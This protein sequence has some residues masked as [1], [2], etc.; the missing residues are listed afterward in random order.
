MPTSIQTLPK[1]WQP[2]PLLLAE[3]VILVTGVGDGIG[4]AAA[5]SFAAQGAT[6]ILLGKTQGKL[7]Q[8]YDEIVAAGGPEPII[9]PLDLQY[10]TPDMAHELAEI[11]P[12]LVRGKKDAVNERNEPV[13]QTVDYG[14][15]MPALTLALKELTEE[16]EELEKQIDNL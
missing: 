4:R 2:R 8:V 9:T 3:R 6:V 12:Q 16:I 13:Y 5:R 10:L 7:E 11:Y 1:S 14:G 15:L